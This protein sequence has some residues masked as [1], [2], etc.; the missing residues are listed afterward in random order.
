M[1]R[2]NGNKKP[3]VLLIGT[4]GTLSAKIVNGAWKPGELKTDEILK[5][6]PEVAEHVQLKT[7]SLLRID[8]SNMQ[9]EMWLTLAQIIHYELPNYDGIVVTHGTDTMQYSA[10]AISFLLQKLNVPI[11]FTGSQVAPGEIGSDARRNLIDSI[12]V[13]SMGDVAESVIVFNGKIFRGNRTKKLRELDYDAFMCVGMPPLGKVEQTVNFTGEQFPRSHKKKPELINKLETDVA[14]LKIY[15]GFEPTIID[16][17]I[18]KGVKGFVIE[19]FGAGNVPT[20]KRSIIPSIK[21]AT[22][23]DIPVVITTQCSLGSSWA[24]LY[25]VG[26]KAIEA[27]ALPGYDILSETALVKLMWVLGQTN[28]LKR[29]K[30]MMLTNYAGEITPGMKKI[31]HK[32]LW[33]LKM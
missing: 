24:Y 19:G 30:K 23:S 32:S 18:N 10:A 16:N 12:R 21:N 22:K 7:T 11:V 15:P 4:G 3:K 31:D 25:E 5:L 33:E 14:L 20:E 9:P 29:V 13:A 2:K 26:V 8:S 27:G 28:D 6:A 1:V 17:L